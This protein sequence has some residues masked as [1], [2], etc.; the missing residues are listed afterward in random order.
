MTAKDALDEWPRFARGKRIG[1]GIDLLVVTVGGLEAAIF[2]TL[3]LEKKR[4]LIIVYEH[5]RL[6]P[7]RFSVWFFDGRRGAA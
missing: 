5:Q 7:A 3:G 4:P 6:N 1:T 2:R